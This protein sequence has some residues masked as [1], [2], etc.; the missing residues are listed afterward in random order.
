MAK[1]T[2]SAYTATVWIRS[3]M[4]ANFIRGTSNGCGK[5]TRDSSKGEITAR[6]NIKWTIFLIKKARPLFS[7]RSIDY[8]LQTKQCGVTTPLPHQQRRIV[9]AQI[10][11]C[12]R[13][14]TTGTAVNDQF[15]LLFQTIANLVS[16]SQC[17]FLIGQNQCRS[18]QRLP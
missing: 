5:S 12:S 1:S 17:I 8:R 4:G 16:A 13:L 2:G 11:H 3:F 14:Q 9:I 10:N 7:G 6:N 15:D 18:Q